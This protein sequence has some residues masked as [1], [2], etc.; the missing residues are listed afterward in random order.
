MKAID[1]TPEMQA[2]VHRCIAAGIGQATTAERVGVST[3]AL[4]R[5]IETHGIIWRARVWKAGM[6]TRAARNAA[7]VAARQRGE[8]LAAIGARYGITHQRVQ[9]IVARHTHLIRHQVPLVEM[10]HRA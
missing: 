4:R 9:I 6:P 1:W 5:F 3:T 2:E 8:T 7:I 10:E